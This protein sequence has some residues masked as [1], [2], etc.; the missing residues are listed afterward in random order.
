M[1]SQWSNKSMVPERGVEGYHSTSLG[2]ASNTSEFQPNPKPSSHQ[3]CSS[4]Q[5]IV[6]RGRHASVIVW[7]LVMRNV[8]RRGIEVAICR[9]PAFVRP[10]HRAGA[11]VWNVGPR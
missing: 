8:R 10:L 11:K 1:L 2:G 6:R 3:T 7:Q 4:G 5:L 9:T